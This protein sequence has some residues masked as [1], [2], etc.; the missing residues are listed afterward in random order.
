MQSLVHR[1]ACLRTRSI[2]LAAGATLVLGL[3][4]GG[5]AVALPAQAAEIG[6]APTAS[7]ITGNGSFSVATSSISSSVSGFGGGVAYYPTAAGTYPVIAISPGYTARW[8]SLAW[9][10]PRLAS[11]GFV[12]V[13]IETN[14]V[15]DQPASRGNQL[16]AALD[17]AVSSS[18]PS[19]VRS[20]ADSNRRG[21]AGHSMGGGGTLEALKD[22]TSGRIMAGVAMTPW[23]TD[24]TWPEVSE[25]VAILGSENDTVAPPASHAIP[26]YNSVAGPKSY[27]ELN[28]A[29]HFAPNS[30]NPTLSRLIVSWFKRYLEQDARFTPFTCGF[31]GTAVSDF[32][33]NAC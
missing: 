14:S 21:V 23:N 28:G 19:A 18:A 33:T 24:K 12:V 7:N 30:T 26:F 13:G 8:S 9:L 3:A 27:V 5:V 32:R 11:W 25:P 6:Q 16:R 29:S 17:W 4:A 2:R 22:D 15:F 31:G 20:R 10:G 1:L